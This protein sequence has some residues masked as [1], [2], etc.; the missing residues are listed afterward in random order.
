MVSFGG[1]VAR[2]GY[3]LLFWLAVPAGLVAWALAAGP[4]VPLTAVR[5]PAAGAAAA[6]VGLAMLMAGTWQLIARGGGLP[7]NPF[8]PTRLVRSGIY[9]WLRS[10]IY[11]GF[12]LVCAGVSIGL[13]SASGLW[14]VTPV[15]WLA[16]AALVYGYERHD[17][18]RRFGPDAGRAPRLSLPRGEAEAPTVAHRAAVYSWVLLPWL[19]AYY[20][21]QALGPAPDAFPL[22]LPFERQWPVLQWTELLYASVYVFVPVTPL[23]ARTQRALRRFAIQGLVSTVIVTLIWLAVP[24]LELNRPFAP[25]GF[26]GRLLAYEQTHSTGVAA[27]PAFHVLWALIA[28]DAW[29]ANARTTGPRGWAW[30]GWVWATAIAASCITTGMHTVLEVAAAVAAF[31]LVRRYDWAWGRL[32]GAVETLA[33][34]WREWRIGR[35]RVIS[36]GVWAAAA[37][38]IGL[39]IAGAAAGRDL[40][41]AVLLVA[42]CALAGAGLWAQVLEGSSK[43]LRP[44]GWYG[45]LLGGTLGALAAGLL[46]APVMRLLAAFFIAAPWIQSLGRLRCLVQ[47]CCHG[48]PAPPEIGI[49]YRHPRSRVTRLANLAGTPVHPTP[50]YSIGANLVIGIVLL[51]LRALAAPDTV[52]VGAY[53]MLGG[54]ARF[55]EESY[56]GEPQTAIVGGLRIYQWLA[57]ACLLAGIVLTALPAAP[58]PSGLATP[59]L[60]LVLAAMGMALISG[61]AMGVDFPASNRRFSRLAP[62]D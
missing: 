13:G 35:A 52:L 47:G 32:R 24:V 58:G 7:M 50:L 57:A 61:F 5:S 27:F 46:G 39:P 23:L 15:A 34:S 1:V 6:G 49:R 20:A 14:L 17:L 48:A 28:A 33:N 29:A 12:G 25:H 26:P 55:V 60:R 62:A 8:P 43:L 45:G 9:R 16:A 4:N 10:P 51:R 21:V 54:L 3:G 18:L 30:I 59:D 31:P 36:H 42:L 2:L 41:A 11:I 37:A 44:F 40:F 38:L 56:R 19:V 53:L 22:A